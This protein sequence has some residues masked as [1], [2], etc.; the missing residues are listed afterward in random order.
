MKIGQKLKALRQERGLTQVELAKKSGV[1]I[2]SIKRYETRDENITIENIN[3]LANALD[4]DSSYFL[5][6]SVSKLSLSHEEKELISLYR[7]F[8]EEEREIILD[9]WRAKARRIEYE[10]KKA[11]AKNTQT[12]PK[13]SLDAKVTTSAA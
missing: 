2:Q 9:E 3:K 5:S 8:D 6:P 11:A 12:P 13:P 4:V 7:K 10:Q 1:S